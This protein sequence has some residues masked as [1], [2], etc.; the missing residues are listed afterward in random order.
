MV[1]EHPGLHGAVVTG[2]HSGAIGAI[3]QVADGQTGLGGDVEEYV[4]L[5][6]GPWQRHQEGIGGRR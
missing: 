5:Q 3:L 4:L 6:G 1:A 2:L